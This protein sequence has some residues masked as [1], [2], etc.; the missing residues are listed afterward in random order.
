LNASWSPDGREIF[1]WETGQVGRLMKVPFEARPEPKLGKPQALFEAPLPMVDRL[2]LTPD[3]QRFVMV[4]TQPEEETP[5]Q[6]VVIP[7]FLEETK[8]RFSAKRP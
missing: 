3:G 7:G 6:I 2:T 1:Y 8:A 4:Q 5:S